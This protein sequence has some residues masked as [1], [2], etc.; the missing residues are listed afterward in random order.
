PKILEESPSC[1]D[2]YQ[3]CCDV[4]C[5]LE[6]ETQVFDLINQFAQKHSLKPTKTQSI[7]VPS[8]TKP[9]KLDVE[10]KVNFTGQG[11][12]LDL[13]DSEEIIRLLKSEAKVNSVSWQL[14]ST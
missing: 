12:K 7:N 6:A 9:E 13:A 5:L 3:Y 8:R 2:D 1:S 14:L 11:K 10:L 4:L